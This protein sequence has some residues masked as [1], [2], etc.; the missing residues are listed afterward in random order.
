MLAG[1]D[2]RLTV[3][4][5]SQRAVAGD[6]DLKHRRR[7]PGGKLLNRGIELLQYGWRFGWTRSHCLGFVQ[8]RLCGFAS[9]GWG[10]RPGLLAEA[11]RVQPQTAQACRK[12]KER[13]S[14]FTFCTANEQL[15][16][17]SWTHF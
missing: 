12:N 15:H 5:L 11:R 16:G 14:E 2:R 7:Y 13:V 1:D 4:A 8:V 9:N 3:T 6:H 17:D 10:L